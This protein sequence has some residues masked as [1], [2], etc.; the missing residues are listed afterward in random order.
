MFF[1]W[2]KT[3][4]RQRH[5][6]SLSD[7][8]SAPKA[9]WLINKLEHTS[10]IHVEVVRQQKSEQFNIVRD[11]CGWAGYLGTAQTRPWEHDCNALSDN[12]RQFM[13]ARSTQ[14]Q[15]P[16]PSSWVRQKL[17]QPSR[18][19]SSSKSLQGGHCG[20]HCL[21][22]HDAAVTECI[23][24]PSICEI[25]RVAAVSASSQAFSPKAIWALAP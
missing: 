24:T 8:E 20:N 23:L 16:I 17:L 7:Q 12:K 19:V 9:K 1:A 2:L 25:M 5:R 11:R 22:S 15:R 10:H 6:H 13:T 18:D 3:T 21:G 14:G 4:D